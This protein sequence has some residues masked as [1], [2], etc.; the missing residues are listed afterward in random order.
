MPDFREKLS[1]VK[2]FLLDMDGTVYLGNKLIGDMKNT[3]SSIRNSGRR[4]VF[5]TNNSSKSAE[6]Y[7]E[8]LR[9]LDIY[10]EAD[11]IFTSGMAT[12]EYL[13]ENHPN[14]SVYLVGT[15][16]LKEEWKKAGVPLTEGK[17]DIAVLA[18]DTTLTYEKLCKLTD[19][20][21]GGAEFIATHP[22]L[23]CPAE[24]FSIPD[25]GSMLEMVYLATGRRPSVICGKPY[26]AMGKAV[27]RFL[28]LKKEELL[29][30][31]DRLHTDIAFGVKNGFF[32]LLV[33]SGEATREDY[34]KCGMTVDLALN[35]LNDIVEYL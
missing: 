34:E 31:G 30:A 32:S 27:A 2:C 28:G 9:K 21:Q 19:L 11:D 12:V 8:K 24:G 22:D 4:I 25:V 3:L 16:A 1:K 23:V 17:A 10:D 5:L 29:M 15:D 13:S 18:F 7:R 33:Y 35:S 20:I 26:E 6:T 14:K